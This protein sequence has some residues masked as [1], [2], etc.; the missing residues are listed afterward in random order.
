[1]PEITHHFAHLTQLRLHYVTA[2]QGEPVV[3]LHGWPQTWYSW[4]RV[5]P[6]LAAHHFVIAPDLRGLGDSGRPESGYDKRTIAAD[7][8]ELMTSVLHLP[9]FFLVG[10]DWGGPV[11]FSLAAHYPKAVRRLAIIDVAI[12][13]DGNPGINQGGRRWH[14]GFHQTLDL[15]EALVA[16]REE[17]Y[18]GWFYR[19][20]GARA[21]AI[22][23]TAIAEYLRA[24][25]EPGALHSGFEYYRNIARDIA[26]NEAI[27]ANGKLAVPVL[28]LGGTDGW[29]RG[30]EV[31]HSCKRVAADVRGGVIANA[32]HWVPEE[33]PQELA[34]QL[35]AFFRGEL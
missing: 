13:G 2:G 24:Y 8:H 4:H 30:M 14:H 15:P 9:S 1:M 34:Q 33:Q 5:I 22:D 12:P 11:A 32:G 7:I 18:L 35:L 16:G 19:N 10:H 23:Q 31:V 25:R 29:G 6:L 3:L 27:L 21:D 26:D 20:Y 28:A 17:I